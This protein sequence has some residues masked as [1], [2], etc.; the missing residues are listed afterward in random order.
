MKDIPLKAISFSDYIWM[1]TQT[2]KFEDSILLQNRVTE[3]GEEYPDCHSLLKIAVAECESSRIAL[4]SLPYYLTIISHV[5]F[6][7]KYCG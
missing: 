4:K 5:Q 1:V 2:Y 7:R 6:M 3:S